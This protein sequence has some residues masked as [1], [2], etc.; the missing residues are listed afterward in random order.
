MSD[1]MVLKQ[2][3]RWHGLQNENEMID[4]IFIPRLLLCDAPTLLK[5]RVLWTRCGE[6]TDP[7]KVLS[8]LDIFEATGGTTQFS[9]RPS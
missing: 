9:S 8:V 4:K 1:E 5:R 2:A 6:I 3:A 7:V